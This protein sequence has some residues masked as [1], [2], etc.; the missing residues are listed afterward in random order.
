MQIQIDRQID[1]QRQIQI[2]IDS[3]IGRQIDIEGASTPLLLT[4]RFSSCS[5]QP[6]RK[7]SRHSSTSICGLAP[8]NAAFKPPQR[9]LLTIHRVSPRTRQIDITEIERGGRTRGVYTQLQLARQI[10]RYR[11]IDIDRQIQR[12]SLPPS[13]LTSNPPPLFFPF[14]RFPATQKASPT[15][16]SLDILASTP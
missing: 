16:S 4:H 12:V 9:A 14:F 11:W 2:D 15:H 8:L 7:P 5:F 6:R 13:S 10:D 1:R 3:Q